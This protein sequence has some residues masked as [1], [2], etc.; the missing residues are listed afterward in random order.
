M[1]QGMGQARAHRLLALVLARYN[2][3]LEQLVHAGTESWDWGSVPPKSDGY[4]IVGQDKASLCLN[5]Q[6]TDLLRQTR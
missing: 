5:T 1:E 2:C 3:W 6:L 4:W